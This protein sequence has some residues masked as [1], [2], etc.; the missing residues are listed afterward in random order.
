MDLLT[1][2]HARSGVV[3]QQDVLR[4]GFTRYAIRRALEQGGLR[5]IRGGWLATQA[6][7]DPLVHAASLGGRLGCVSATRHH[8]LWTLD[9]ARLHITV[10]PH[11]SRHRPA[12]AVLHWS[13]GPVA[14]HPYELIEPVVNALVQVADCRPFDEAVAVWESALRSGRVSAGLL[15][16]MPIR[17]AAA[18]LVRSASTMLSDSG[19]E[20]IPVVRLGRIGITVRQQVVLDGHPV[21]GLIGERLVYQIDGYEFHRGPAQRERDLAQDR[22]LRL[23]GFTVFRYGYRQ[24]LAE[25]DSV[26][27]EIRLAVAQ[28]LHLAA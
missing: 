19:I 7:P 1:W 27:D 9:D 5:R 13:V 20:S 23:M 26:E 14:G 17:S 10:P 4:A 21:D 6:A 12:G 3:H 25:W 16:R 24:I 28:R 11:S 22:R 8:G 18:R 2:A 15:E